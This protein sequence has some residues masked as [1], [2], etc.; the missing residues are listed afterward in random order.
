M[1]DRLAVYMLDVGQG[2]CTVVLLPD[3][4][5]VIFDCADDHVLRK[6]L[7]GWNTPAI[8]AFV[9]SHLDQDHIAGALQFLRGWTRPIEG[10]YLSTDRDVGVDHDDAKRA[11]ALL[12]YA[13]EQSRDQGARRRRWELLPNTRDRRHLVSGPGWSVTLL[14][15]R[16]GQVIRR[17]REGEWEEANRYSSILR[18]QAG[19]SAMLIGGDAP[20]LSWSE[21]PPEEL[22]AEAFRIPHH[23]G[24]LNDGG[25]P[26]GWSVDRLYNDV[27]APTALISV[28]TNNAHGHPMEPWVKPITGG[29]PCR[30]LCTQVTA[31]CHGPL[32][33]PGTDGRMERDPVEL[34]ALRRR[35]ITEQH[36]WTEP[37]YRHLTDR[38]GQ[39]EKGRLEVPCA[40]TVVVKLYL[41]GHVEVLPSRGGEHE[42]IVDDWEHPLCRP[43]VP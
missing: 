2:D 20:L 35:V 1:N 8:A 41:N 4:R 11:K 30:L 25:T 18:V 33:V 7:D 17:E 3:D 38:R 29:G 19:P 26:V 37:Q 9:L 40:G 42:R 6:V 5:V 36:Q 27:G 28:G 23:G 14:A 31:R 15:P 16:H 13:E 34:A 32:E 21:L 12:D 10:V 43:P 22:K 24:A 39:V